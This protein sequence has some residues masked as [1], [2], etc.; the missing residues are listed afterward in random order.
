MGQDFQPPPTTIIARIQGNST[1][2]CTYGS[3]SSFPGV[4]HDVN[5]FTTSP[6]SMKALL[7]GAN[8][9]ILSQPCLVF[10]DSPASTGVI[11]LFS[12]AECT[13]PSGNNDTLA[14]NSCLE[15]NQ[16]SA[17]S[18]SAFPSCDNNVQA[19]LYIS[20]LTE[21]QKPTIWPSVSSSTIGQCLTFD[22]GV[23]IGSAAFVCVDTTSTLTPT[24]SST[25]TAKA[26]KSS[27]TSTVDSSLNTEAP[28]NSGQSS[29]SGGGISQS[30]KINIA[31]GLSIGLAALVVA[32]AAAWYARLGTLYQLRPQRVRWP[33]NSALDPPPTYQEFELRRDSFD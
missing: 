3:E 6:N 7:L 10:A 27:Q 33:M 2:Y 22:T 25:S 13:Q 9:V 24:S 8:L 14:V 1:E 31:I 29:N 5:V 4:F 23:G 12:D 32:I 20:D 16:T 11:Q 18:A 28:Q 15:A 30:D 26:T 17:I 21:C 19:I